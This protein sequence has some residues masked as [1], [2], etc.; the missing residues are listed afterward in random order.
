[1]RRAF[2]TPVV[3]DPSTVCYRGRVQSVRAWARE[4]GLNYQTV[5]SRL[6]RGWTLAE[7]LEGRASHARGKTCRSI[8]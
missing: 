5:K 4:L 7:A 8:P 3:Q 1:V 6:T 2:E